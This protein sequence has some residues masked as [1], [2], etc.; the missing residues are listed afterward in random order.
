M[1]LKCLYL[2]VFSLLIT[3]VLSA[4]NY[5]IEY[6]IVVKEQCSITSWEAIENPQGWTFIGL[7]GE[8]KTVIKTNPSLIFESFTFNNSKENTQYTF[9]REGGTL[10][11]KGSVKGK[12]ISKSYNLKKQ[13]WVQDFNFG[14]KPFL[15]SQDK[16]FHFIILNPYNFDS[17]SMVAKKEG[18]EKIEIDGKTFDALHMTISLTGF[19]SMFWTANL[20][21]DMNTLQLLK[22]VANEGP[23]TPTTIKTLVLNSYKPLNS[24]M[25]TKQSMNIKN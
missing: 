20:W 9:C 6:K 14:L 18:K 16:Y 10:T 24:Q 1:K 8:E 23:N 22:Y 21:Y 19:K 17:N 3:S 4:E 5:Q 25:K 2:I 12:N 7:K 11:A 13:N 15:Q